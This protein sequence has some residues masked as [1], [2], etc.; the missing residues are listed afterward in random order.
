MWIPFFVRLF[1]VAVT[2]NRYLETI[3]TRTVLAV[4]IVVLIAID[5]KTNH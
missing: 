2:L 3:A 5:E 1:E 4:R